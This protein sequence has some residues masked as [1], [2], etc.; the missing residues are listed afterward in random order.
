MSKCFISQNEVG[1]SGFMF[2]NDYD[3]IY[4]F[5]KKKN[6]NTLEIDIV[7]NFQVGFSPNLCSPINCMSFTIL[8]LNP[9]YNF[10]LGWLRLETRLVTLMRQSSQ[11]HFHKHRY[12][13]PY[14]GIEAKQNHILLL[15]WHF[16]NFNP[17]TKRVIFC[18]KKHTMTPLVM[19]STY[20]NLW[21]MSSI[22]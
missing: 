17:I 18:L 16:I 5:T 15:F 14:C 12:D 21:V 7:M 13:L 19:S 22:S 3:D 4:E 10:F 11:G 6:D 9:N 8:V 20:P 2:C 1:C